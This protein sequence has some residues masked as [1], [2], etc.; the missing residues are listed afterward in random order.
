[1]PHVQ[2]LDAA[3]ESREFELGRVDLTRLGGISFDRS[4]NCRRRRVAA[5]VRAHNRTRAGCLNLA[6]KYADKIRIGTDP[7]GRVRTDHPSAHTQ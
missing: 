1:M 3:D 4:A 6:A 2:S 5:D 7:H